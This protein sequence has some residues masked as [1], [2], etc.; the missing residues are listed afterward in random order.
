M[1]TI[2]QVSLR[3]DFFTRFPWLLLALKRLESRLA[4]DGDH[5]RVEQGNE[6][7]LRS[8]PSETPPM[9]RIQHLADRQP[10]TLRDSGSRKVPQRRV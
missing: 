4:T 1:T 7:A 10:G 8:S 3:I 6:L 2:W 5:R 9:A